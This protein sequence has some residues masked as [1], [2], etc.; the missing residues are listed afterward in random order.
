M[1][2]TLKMEGG[3]HLSEILNDILNFYEGLLSWIPNQI[4]SL[5]G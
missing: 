5:Y 4:S 1:S 2:F 3:K